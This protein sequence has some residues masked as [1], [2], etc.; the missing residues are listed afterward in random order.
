VDALEPN[1][2]REPEEKERLWTWNFLKICVISLIVGLALNMTNN[3]LSLYIKATYGSNTMSGVLSVGFALASMVFRLLGGRISDRFGRILLQIVGMSLSI[4]AVLGIG[5]SRSLVLLVAFRILQG[6]GHSVS[7][8]TVTAAGV[9]ITPP[10]RMNEGSSFVTMGFFLSSAVAATL[11][12]A[13]IGDSEAYSRVFFFVAA[14]LAVGILLAATTRLTKD[15]QYLKNQARAQ[16]A[17]KATR[18]RGVRELFELRA[19]PAGVL[20]TIISLAFSILN[21]FLLVF[22]REQGIAGAGWF[23][24]L[25][26]I[27]TLLARTFAGQLA[28]RHGPQG[29]L[30]LCLGSGIVCF[31]L[32]ALTRSPVLFF[33][34]G[35]L[36]GLLNGIAGPVCYAHAIRCSPQD[37]RGSATGT[38]YLSADIANGLGALLWAVIIDGIGFTGSFLIGAGVLVLAVVLSFPILR[39]RPR[40][41]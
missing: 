20:Y 39:Y 11:V 23:F 5:L 1:L 15:P 3:T 40:E 8:T 30:L 16:A 2:P 31:L 10:G 13:L 4:A 24:T 14:I 12:L 27:T 17:P 41:L 9:D 34:A 37:R 21:T 22:A 33:I 35:G 19:V 18:P 36:F 29:V 32:L 28:D 38:F 26:A 25:S 6:V 7:N